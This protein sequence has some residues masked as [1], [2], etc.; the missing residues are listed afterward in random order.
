LEKESSDP[1]FFLHILPFANMEGVS[2]QSALDV[3]D[4]DEILRVLA[5]H[6]NIYPKLPTRALREVL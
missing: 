6:I 4:W 1:L 2:A 3:V 5:E